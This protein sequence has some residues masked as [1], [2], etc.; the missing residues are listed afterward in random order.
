MSNPIILKMQYLRGHKGMIQCIDS[1]QNLLLTASD[2]K[3]CRIW[4]IQ[5]LKT[6]QCIVHSKEVQNV[7]FFE[8]NK[9][10]TTSYSN[11]NLLTH[12]R[13]IFMT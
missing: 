12:S 11:V 10:M 3:T 6:V 8:E 5:N 13:F 7:H 2:D 9:V 4:D 1:N